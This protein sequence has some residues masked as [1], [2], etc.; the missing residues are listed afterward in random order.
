VT[1]CQRHPGSIGHI[2]PR[3]QPATA[4]GPLVTIGLV[5]AQRSLTTSALAASFLIAFLA[6]AACGSVARPGVPSPTPDSGIE[7]TTQASP[8]CPVVSPGNACPPRAISATVVVLD[9][10]G[11][12]VTRFTS[13]ADGSFRVALTPGAYTLSQP[14]S[15]SRVLPRL[16]PVRVQVVAGRYTSVV[17]DFDTGIR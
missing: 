6:L 7:G 13:G 11:H 10:A 3:G 1:R 8:T 5:K 15:P 9:Q 14:T 4:G 12:E 17:L 2:D 16:Q